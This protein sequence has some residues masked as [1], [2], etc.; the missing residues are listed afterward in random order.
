MQD[1]ATFVRQ[2]ISVVFAAPSPHSIKRRKVEKLMANVQ[3]DWRWSHDARE[4]RCKHPGCRAWRN[5]DDVAK[6]PE[7]LLAKACG[8]APKERPALPD[9]LPTLTMSMTRDE[10]DVWR[11]VSKN[12]RTI[13]ELIDYLHALEGTET[14]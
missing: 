4:F 13:N 9:E 10:R 3:H 7:T 12:R 5:V 2:A 11:A 1:T 8:Y 14:K 6:N